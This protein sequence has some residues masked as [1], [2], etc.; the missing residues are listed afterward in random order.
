MSTIPTP[1]TEASMSRAMS[2]EKQPRVVIV[3]GGFGGLQAALALRKAPVQVT[4]IDRTNHHLFQPLLYQVATAGLSPAHIA[5]PIRDILRNQRNAE[6]LMAEVVGV[7]TQER[8]VLLREGAVDAADYDYLILATG[9]RYNYFG[10][11]EW[12][13]IAPSLK[14]IA[15]ATAIRQKILLAFEKAE[16][17]TDP[18]RQQALMTFVLV[19]GGPT[20]VE[21][22]GSMAE[23]AHMA[24]ARDFRHIRPET[25]RII[26]VEASDRVLG[27]FPE[28]LAL[29]A[30]KALRDL[31]VEVMTGVKVESVDESGVAVSGKRIDCSTVIW[32]AGVVATPAARWLGAEADRG[33]RVLVN[34][35]L[36]VPGHPEVFV[37]GDAAHVEEKGAPLP[38]V[39]PVAMQQGRYVARLIK[40]R[41]ANRGEIG[42]FRYKDKGNLATV[43]RSFAILDLGRIKLRGFI[44]WV[45]WLFIHIWY[46]I[47]FRN[48]VSV[49]FQWAWAYF[50][51]QRAA[52][53]ITPPTGAATSVPATSAEVRDRQ[54]AA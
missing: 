16:I 19:G 1:Q 24:L 41:V 26:L 3:G 36:S 35:D 18:A 38:G 52:R 48:R 37:I 15:D 25:A 30:Q 49:L 9:A 46:L 32:T 29:D 23:L 14:N 2:S 44:A 21:M 31:G 54:E 8:R 34:E 51:F 20:G 39:A 50:T 7:D 22:A 17:E 33:G 10:H 4:V 11:D 28:K 12:E 42:P 47:G 5:A 27:N 53:I 40:S 43:G 6:V 45:M 13:Q